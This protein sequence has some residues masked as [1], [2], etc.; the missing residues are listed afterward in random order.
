MFDLLVVAVLQRGA[1]A[2]FKKQQQKTAMRNK[3]DDSE[4]IV[5]LYLTDF[6]PP[7]VGVKAT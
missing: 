1:T 2:L 5:P 6:I 7:C 4:K 3:S